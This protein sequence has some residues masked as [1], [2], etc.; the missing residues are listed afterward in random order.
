MTCDDSLTDRRFLVGID[1]GMHHT[2]IAAAWLEGYYSF[3]S[4]VVMTLT[5]PS[6]EDVV[7]AVLAATPIDAGTTTVVVECASIWGG[8]QGFKRARAAMKNRAFAE[9]LAGRLTTRGYDVI[10]A[11]AVK[12]K[13]ST[14][15]AVIHRRIRE[16]M[17]TFIIQGPDT[18]WGDALDAT[19]NLWKLAQ[20][21]KKGIAVWVISLNL[22]V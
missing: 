13:S 10:K 4:L 18:G 8:G 3:S 7:A 9:N 5:S 17:P 2:G 11:E 15:K 14:P 1:P 16:R 12:L 19:W 22:S 20:W 6:E 21:I